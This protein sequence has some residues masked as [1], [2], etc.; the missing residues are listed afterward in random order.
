M[1]TAIGL[2][3][4]DELPLPET[5]RDAVLLRASGLG[6]AARAALDVAAVMGIEFDVAH[7]VRGRRR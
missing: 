6:E 1:A 2:A 7:G 5:V 4:G 3:P